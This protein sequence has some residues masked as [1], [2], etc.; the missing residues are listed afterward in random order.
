MRKLELGSN[1]NKISEK[2]YYNC[3]ALMNIPD[4]NKNYVTEDGI[5]YSADIKKLIRYP[6]LKAGIY[7]LPGTVHIVSPYAFTGCQKL[8]SLELNG[9]IT[10]FPLSQLNGCISLERLVLPENLQ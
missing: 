3:G 4:G 2:T 10:D 9:Y 6:G 8:K 7:M 5:L 1:V